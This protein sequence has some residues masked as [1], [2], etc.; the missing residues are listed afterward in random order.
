[1]SWLYLLHKCP[2]RPRMC[3]VCALP[4]QKVLYSAARCAHF[5]RQTGNKKEDVPP[6]SQVLLSG[7]QHSPES[8]LHFLHRQP[9]PGYKPAF[10][11]FNRNVC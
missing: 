11:K 8:A 2:K 5:Q 6:S 9:I 7:C 3:L 10:L 4:P 1:L